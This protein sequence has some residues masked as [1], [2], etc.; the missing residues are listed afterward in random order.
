MTRHNGMYFST[1]DSDNDQY[2]QNCALLY[3]SVKPAGGWW[4]HRCWNINPNNFY[5]IL[6][7]ELAGSNFIEMKIRPLNCII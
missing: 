5:S 7:N 6:L 3:G 4:Y 2:S 1:K